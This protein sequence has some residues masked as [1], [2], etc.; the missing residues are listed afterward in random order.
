QEVEAVCD[1]VLILRRGDLV[2]DAKLADLRQSKQLLLDTSLELEAEALAEVEG[3]CEWERVEP[4]RYRV[5][6]ADDADPRQVG[7]A[8][9][10]VV[11]GA[12]AELYQLKVEQRDLET[13]FRQ[14]NQGVERAA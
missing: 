13:L 11:A 10:R 5:K 4:E 8:L 6:L 2:V 7:A 14:V 1:R 12:K 9:A 3:V